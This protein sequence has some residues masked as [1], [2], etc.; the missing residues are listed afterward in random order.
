MTDPGLTVCEVGVVSL[1]GVVVR[2]IGGAAQQQY[3]EKTR[4]LE[5]SRCLVAGIDVGKYEALCL[6][7]DHRGELVGQPLTFRL[8][9]AGA[10]ALER[11]LAAAVQQRSALSVRVGVE[12]AGH[13]HRAIVSRLVMAGHDLVELN[14]AHVKAARAQQGARRLKT[15]LRD[16]AAIVDLLI[17]GGGRSPQQRSA[18]LGRAAGLG[19]AAAPPDPGA[20][21]ADEPAARDAGP[22]LPGPGRLLQR[23]ARH[24]RRPAPAA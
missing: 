14:P 7:A 19:R 16:A 12:T 18:A 23:P 5:A 22:G 17:S 3:V 1:R 9:Q 6:I 15:D 20:D 8:T 4:A 21:R 11:Q 24:P 10:V 13:Y 2:F